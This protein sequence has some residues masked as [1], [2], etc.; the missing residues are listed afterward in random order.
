L[1]VLPDDDAL[2]L[3]PPDLFEGLALPRWHEAVRWLHR[4]PPGIDFSELA[5]HRHPAQVRLALEELLAHQLSLRRQR[6]AVKRQGAPALRPAGKLAT[7][8]R[9]ALPFALTGA[10]Q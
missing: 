1:D 8:L 2:E 7:R 6:L 9:R 10:Q 5:G 4:P 3:L